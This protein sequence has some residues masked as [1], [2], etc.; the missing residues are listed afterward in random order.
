MSYLLTEAGGVLQQ[1]SGAFLLWSD[2][3]GVP[4]VPLHL[5]FTDSERKIVDGVAYI[6]NIVAQQ[7]QGGDKE[8]YR[9]ACKLQE[10][11]MTESEAL[12]ALVDWNRTN[13]TPP[14]STSDLLY[15]VRRAYEVSAC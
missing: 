3:V 2:E 10:S 7:G 13:A 15:K 6:K 12:A 14:W 4:T 9:A 8:T 1:E 5:V 11:G